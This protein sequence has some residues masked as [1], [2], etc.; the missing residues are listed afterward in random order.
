[1]VSNQQEAVSPAVPK[2]PYRD[3]VVREL[4]QRIPD[5]DVALV[6]GDYK[7]DN[8]LLHPTEP[9]VVAVLDWELSTI[10]HPMSDVSNLF[11]TIYFGP[12]APDSIS[13]GGIV[14]MPDLDKS[15]IPTQEEFLQMYSDLSGRKIDKAQ[16]HYFLTFYFWRGAIISQGIGARLVAGQASSTQG[17]EFFVKGI[18]V[19]AEMMKNELDELIRLQGPA[20]RPP[21][22]IGKNLRLEDD[23][24]HKS[25]N[26][27]SNY[28][29]SVYCNFHS[30]SGRMGG[31]MRI[32]NRPNENFAEVTL[33]V[34]ALD[35]KTTLFHFSRPK[36]ASNNG[37][38][39]ELAGGG[40]ISL[41]VKR[42]ME[43]VTLSFKG[44]AHHLK[45]P[46]LLR[47]PE[48]LFRK[49][50]HEV[51]AVETSF[52]VDFIGCGPVFGAAAGD[53][54]KKSDSSAAA[55]DDFAKNHYEQHGRAVGSLNFSEKLPGGETT[56]Q[57]HVGVDGCGLRD[58]SW[59][60]RY[61]QAISSYRWVT[62]N[63]GPQCGLTFTVIGTSGAHM[64]M[65]IGKDELVVFRKCSIK[66][67]YCEET[68]DKDVGSEWFAGV[69][70]PSNA[71][72]KR[73][74]ELVITAEDAE[75]RPQMRLE[76]L[77]RALGFVPL[78]NRRA[79][80]ITY[81]G[82]AFTEYTVQSLSGFDAAVLKAGA[83]GYGMSEYLDQSD[84]NSKL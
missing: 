71:P 53:S 81:L 8:F 6:H 28:N 75:G 67:R 18:P 2:I 7:F 69:N 4:K 33:C 79:E 26:E 59:G 30:S 11:A 19:M 34:F 40:K 1:M 74:A 83:K 5:D 61:W 82:E 31:F 21:T 46:Y 13:G 35:T 55:G 50:R 10:G 45:K 9:R 39:C 14:G 76:V 38:E 15:G 51:S 25:K 44:K 20:P 48:T 65:H 27:A 64:A 68:N 56:V 49:Q 32:G 63:F 17:A 41:R 66:T 54:K 3:E 62:A 12:Y 42:P 70:R 60:P 43:H 29:E 84:E 52:Q 37:W 77:G 58:H 16:W 36:I 47:D 78:R 24:T 22:M 72:S 23:Y 73:H 80:K 57:T